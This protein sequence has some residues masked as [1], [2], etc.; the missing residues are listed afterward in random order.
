MKRL[1]ALAMLLIT[2]CAANSGVVQTA[3]NRF[4]VS[5]QA[6]TGFS[7]LGNLRAE[8]LH[9]AQAHCASSGLQVNELGGRESQPPYVAGNFPRVEIEFECV[10]A[11]PPSASPAPR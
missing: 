5:R 7:G 11:P 10:A 1:A 2:G 8:A 6:R 4:M 9:E 3:P